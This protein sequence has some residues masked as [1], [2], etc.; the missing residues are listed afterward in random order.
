MKEFF[1]KKSVASLIAFVALL[2]VFAAAAWTMSHAEREGTEWHSDWPVT[3]SVKDGVADPSQTTHEFTIIKEGQYHLTLLGLPEGIKEASK[4]KASDLGFITTVLLL[5]AA[6][7]EV[8]GN[9]GAAVRSDMTLDLKPGNY[10][11][12]LYYHTDK[13]A[14]MKFATEWLCGSRNV[15][16]WA[17]EQHFEELQRNGSWT[18]HYEMSVYPDTFLDGYRIGVLFGILIAACVCVILLCVVTKG[19]HLQSAKYDERQEM[20]RGRGFRYAF[21]VS[22]M[23]IGGTLVCSMMGF[24][25]PATEQ[26]LVAFGLLIGITVYS[27]YCVLH[28]A[29][30]P[31]NQKWLSFVVVTFFVGLINLAFVIFDIING[32]LIVDGQLG[33]GSLNLGCAIMLLTIGSLS[34]FKYL[35]NKKQALETEEEDEEME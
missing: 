16:S 4:V 22:M 14:F 5:D 24:L 32:T 21:A 3:V 11:M 13:A 17:R 9:T 35:A 25:R 29:Y 26:T 27:S 6:G 33:D 28:E 30:F 20:E 12:L 19:N 23:F 15:E 10:Q 7:E 2:C 34:L 8:F 31:L 18:I 1:T